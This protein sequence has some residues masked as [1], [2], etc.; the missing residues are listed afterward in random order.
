ML[1]PFAPAI[2]GTAAENTVP[3]ARRGDGIKL[4]NV[5]F[6]FLSFAA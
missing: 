1:N 6:Q 2:Y 5:S 4:F 3:V